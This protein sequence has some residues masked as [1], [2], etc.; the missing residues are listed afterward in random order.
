ML[1]YHTLKSMVIYNKFD[2]VLPKGNI[3]PGFG[4]VLFILSP[5]RHKGYEL[6]GN[7]LHLSQSLY[8]HLMIDFV[9][10]EKIGYKRYVKNNSGE[11]K[12]ELA[13]LTTYDSFI[14]VTNSNKSNILKNKK[15]LVVNLGEW[16]DIYFTYQIKKS[17]SDICMNF[18]SFLN[19]RINS[20]DFSSISENEELKYKKIIF[21]DISQ[22]ISDDNKLSFSKKSLNN[23][24]SILLYSLYKYPELVQN[25]NNVDILIGSTLSNSIL[26]IN[27]EDLTKSNYN[28]IKS[29][30]CNLLSTGSIEPSEIDEK[31]IDEGV[32]DVSVDKMNTNQ[33][34]TKIDQNRKKK[35]VHIKNKILSELTKG[36]IGNIDDI[37]DDEDDSDIEVDD[38]KI[39]QIKN[40]A[41]NYLDD[42]PD[43][44]ENEDISEALTEVEKEINK[45]YYIKEFSPKYTDKQLKEIQELANIQNTTIGNIDDS[46]ND[47]E[48][49][50]IDESDYSSA[51]DTMNPNIIK[52]KFVNFEKSYNKKKLEKDIDNA[53]AALSN[54]STKVY[55]VGKE[56]EDT[57]TPLD[58]KKTL[59]YYLKDERGNKMK[60]K[61]DVPVIF[62]D[63]YMMIKGNK[64]VIQHMLILKPLVK[65]GKDTV[66]IATNYQKMFISRKGSVDLKSNALFRYL[67]ANKGKLSVIFGNGAIV[68]KHFKSTM[69]YNLIAK[70][71]IEFKIDD[72]IFILNPLKIDEMIKSGKIDTSKI[73]FNKEIIIGISKDKKPI[74]MKTNESFVDIVFQYLPEKDKESIKKYG[75]KSNG[76]R[77]LMYSKCKPLT[78]DCPL[79]LLLLYF[80]GFSK[81][82]EKAGIEYELI[83]KEEGKKPKVD[84]FEYG[85]IELEDGYIK[86]KRY[87]TE[88]SLLM[89]G[90]NNL[91][92]HLYSI[93]GLD[94]KDTY[95][96]LLTN[97]YQYAN[98][99]FNLDQYYDFMIDPITKEI[100]HD[101]HLP[102]DI[103]SLCLLANKMLKT[104]EHSKESRM[105]SMRIRSNEIIP[106][107]TYK[108]VTNAYNVY[109]KSQHRKKP[110]PISVKQDAVIRSLL[111]QSASAMNDASSLNPILEISK[112]RAITYK[113]ENGT[114]MDNA[115]TLDIRAY[116]ESMLGVLG[117]TTSP[118]AGC[119]I[120]RQLTLEPNITSTRGYIDVAGQKHVEELNAAQL[121][122]PSE[123]LTPLG[124]QHDDPT[125]TAMSYKQTM[126][127]VL[128]EESDP[129][130]IGNGV[131]KVLPQ[132]LSSDFVIT[133]EEDGKVIEQTEDFI[134][135]QYKSGKYRCIDLSSKVKKNS[136]A[137][138][139]IASTLSSNLKPGMKFK[140]FDVLAWD[141]KAFK[142]SKTSGEASMRLGPLLKIAVIPEW[143]IFE[144]SAPLTK[145]AS[146][147][148]V[149]QMAMPV[150]VSLDKSAYV[151]KILK[152][153]DK[154][155]AGDSVIVFDNYHEDEDVLAM[156]QSMR[157][158]LAEDIIETGMTKKTS[159][160]TG[161]ISNIEIN[162]T[163]PVEE[164]SESLQKIVKD[165]WKNIEK[166]NAIL[167]KYS[168]PGDMNFYKSGN[169]I[170][171]VSTPV[172][173]DYQG[174]VKGKVVNEGVL[175]TFYVRF[176]DVLS[177]GDKI[178]SEFALKGICSHII[179][180]GLEP[181]T[182]NDPDESIDL[183]VAPL[184]VSAR[185]TPTLFPAMFAN[186]ILIKAKKH[187]KEYWN[188]N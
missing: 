66:Q 29:K 143:D 20:D 21:L 72:N 9:Y 118:D 97:I 84:L 99:S 31:I 135:V 81:V 70:K 168:N 109:R 73:D 22:W 75:R 115:F 57:S 96:Y 184:S 47:L 155:N 68:N 23:P 1:H 46:I 120:N 173:P 132:H 105:E 92:M 106:Y 11:F 128:T 4:N 166:R 8:K 164:L 160:Y 34:I 40:I 71:I 167:T 178:A 41:S 152:V 119:G 140:K 159:H 142:K 60:L 76:G 122:A 16:L 113:G 13:N 182:E 52:S 64:K 126:Y 54:A 62:D 33:L 102:T 2:I 3:R 86:W 12:Q 147:K 55:V 77:L 176:D 149:T 137:G 154:V 61:F 129:V 125:R 17:Y 153:G 111:K 48:S 69:E 157:E 124:A 114:N 53:V 82:M 107:H 179:E 172:E 146:N 58:L 39:N 117:M 139:Y 10:N 181:Y 112:L 133:A 98:Q 162:T 93:D 104:D 91:P 175:I 141:D 28:K 169:V 63:H 186:K 185:K 15:N 19:K 101:M 24:I 26:K 37:T 187:L 5:N 38:D 148:L 67:N 87:P 74:I 88:N 156:L 32:K 14:S 121:L 171:D 18:F 145:K 177:R 103:V 161:V 144:D 36:L 138:F 56:T 80:E 85:L 131:E 163:V 183:I 90:L 116:N 158:D 188:N 94:S 174:K 180:E 170:T 134:V 30:I 35:S 65:T 123:L 50:I 83:P 127:M 136:A 43:L 59:T 130:L 27:F 7:Q 151:S 110:I 89:N 150:S 165:Y 44:L 95:T 45:K 6:L 49:K 79:I 25:I 42:N 108:A 100:L 51:I 78:K